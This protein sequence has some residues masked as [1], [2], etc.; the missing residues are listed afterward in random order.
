KLIMVIP[1][2]EDLILNEILD[3]GSLHIAACE[4]SNLS[5]DKRDYDF[6]EKTADV[7]MAYATIFIYKIIIL[8]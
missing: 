6:E 1:S 7:L 2:F 4:K 8:M 5:R 3:V